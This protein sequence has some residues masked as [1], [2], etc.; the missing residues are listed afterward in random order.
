MKLAVRV[1]SPLGE[2]MVPNV[3]DSDEPGPQNLS[4]TDEDVWSRRVN[5][6][7]EPPPPADASI[8]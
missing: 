6:M 4:S 2:G 5:V 3:P 8:R 1:Y 7:L